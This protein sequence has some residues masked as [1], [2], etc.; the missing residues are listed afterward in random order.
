MQEELRKYLVL[1]E[2]WQ[3]P[4]Q[5][6]LKLQSKLASAK[7]YQETNLGTFPRCLTPTEPGKMDGLAARVGG[8]MPNNLKQYQHW[9]EPS[10]VVGTSVASPLRPYK[11]S[12]QTRKQHN[13]GGGSRWDVRPISG[14]FVPVFRTPHF[15]YMP[16]PVV[17]V[18]V[19]VVFV[20]S[21]WPKH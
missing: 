10:A 8:F 11:L 2:K 21:S 4:L 13:S 1:T 12:Q 6:P 5:S 7:N 9:R 18:V 14:F 19:V 16:L 20:R 17:A 3:K 15:Y